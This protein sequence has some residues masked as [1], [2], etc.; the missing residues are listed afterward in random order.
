MWS[1][2]K[3]KE[4]KSDKLYFNR[5]AFIKTIFIFFLLSAVWTYTCYRFDEFT[6]NDKGL[7]SSMGFLA[8]IPISIYF[9]QDIKPLTF[10]LILYIGTVGVFLFGSFVLFLLGAATNSYLIYSLANS[11][12]VS[13]VYPKFVNH[14]KPFTLLK[15]A[16]IA[17]FLLLVL[18]YYLISIFTEDYY[19]GF[20]V[21]PRF[22]TFNIFQ[23]FLIFPMAIGMSFKKNNQIPQK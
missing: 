12:F 20:Y 10:L 22:I 23:F 18:A 9:G 4:M 8:I 13:I 14:L 5:T 21:N 11:V 7:L 3:L 15:P 6:D 16:I 17:I 1:L 19:F 2:S